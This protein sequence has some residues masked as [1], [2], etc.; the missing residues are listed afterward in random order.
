MGCRC[1]LVFWFGRNRASAFLYPLNLPSLSAQRGLEKG[2]PGARHSVAAGMLTHS[3]A[4]W[5]PQSRRPH[6]HPSK[7][8]RP[9]AANASPH[10]PPG[11][12]CPASGLRGATHP[13]GRTAHRARGAPTGPALF[14]AIPGST[15]GWGSGSDHLHSGRWRMATPGGTPRASLCVHLRCL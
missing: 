9:Q 3:A 11:R 13:R 12:L 8:R 2:P 14:D 1:L 6:E 10:R 7:S 5:H 4:V 15:R